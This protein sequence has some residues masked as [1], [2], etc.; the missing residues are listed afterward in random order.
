[1]DA[2]RSALSL[3]RTLISCRPASKVRGASMYFSGVRVVTTVFPSTNSSASVT[4][5]SP[6]CKVRSGVR[7]A[8]QPTPRCKAGQRGEVEIAIQK[9]GRCAAKPVAL[10][11]GRW[12]RSGPNRRGWQRAA[13]QSHWGT[14]SSP[15]PGGC[16]VRVTSPGPTRPAG[17]WY[18]CL[19]PGAAQSTAPLAVEDHIAVKLKPA[20][21]G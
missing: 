4:A 10:P 13:I 19:R 2:E 5:R 8:R 3:K 21:A 18:G 14:T 20:D 16:Q 12:H 7:R 11:S 6:T 17:G 1:M 9:G 15:W